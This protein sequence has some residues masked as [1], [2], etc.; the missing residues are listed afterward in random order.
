MYL[1]CNNRL[2]YIIHKSKNVPDY[3]NV[4]AFIGKSVILGHI[5]FVGSNSGCLS[6]WFTYSL[7]FFCGK[8]SNK[9]SHPQII[10][11]YLREGAILSCCSLVACTVGILLLEAVPQLKITVHLDSES[12]CLLMKGLRSIG[13]YSIFLFQSMVIFSPAPHKINLSRDPSY[14]I[15]TDWVSDWV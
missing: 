14:L 11:A 9:K 8:K 4:F 10:T 12:C 3:G 6:F 13:I 15:M 2:F 7:T 1:S 5:H